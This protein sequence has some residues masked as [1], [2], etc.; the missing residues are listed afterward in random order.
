VNLTAYLLSL[1]VLV[2]YVLV[3]GAVASA[4]RAKNKDRYGQALGNEGLL[5]AI[6]G[7]L[8]L[9]VLVVAPF[10]GVAKLGGAVVDL[11]IGRWRSPKLPRAEVRRP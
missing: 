11:L 2:T 8:L 1:L 3:A 9:I 6:W 5:G 7:P 4:A 10:L